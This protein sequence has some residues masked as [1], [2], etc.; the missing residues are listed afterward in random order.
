MSYT[1]LVVLT[2]PL[3][4]RYISGELGYLKLENK[5]KEGIFIR[6]NLYYILT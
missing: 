4:D 5:I 6:K 3:P 1:Y 2:Y